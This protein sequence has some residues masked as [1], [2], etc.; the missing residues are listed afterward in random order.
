MGWE[1]HRYY[2]C[3]CCCCHYC[4]YCYYLKKHREKKKIQGNTSYTNRNNFSPPTNWCPASSQAVDFS[5]DLSC[6]CIYHA[7]HHIL[8][9]WSAVLAVSPFQPL[10]CPSPFA[11]G[12]DKKQERPWLLALLS[13]NENI[14]FSPNCFQHKFRT[15]PHTSYYEEISFYPIE[16]PHKRLNCIYSSTHVSQ[17]MGTLSR[18]QY[19][20]CH[21]TELHTNSQEYQDYF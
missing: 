7:W 8:W 14:P 5:T 18:H 13:S 2:Y 9:L 4:H 19:L 16:N 1:N 11:V 20:L 6:S 21:L 17:Y 12:W 15:Q 10:V 3:C